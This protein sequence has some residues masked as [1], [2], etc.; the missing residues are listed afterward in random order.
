MIRGKHCCAT[1]G[2]LK[3][4]RGA[5]HHWW[6]MSRCQTWK[7]WWA[8][9]G[10]YYPIYWLLSWINRCIYQD[11]MIL[12]ADYHGLSCMNWAPLYI[13]IYSPGKIMDWQRVLNTAHLWKWF[14]EFSALSELTH[15]NAETK[16]SHFHS[17]KLHY[18]T[19][20]KQRL[21][22]LILTSDPKPLLTRRPKLC[23]SCSHAYFLRANRC[24][25]PGK[26]GFDVG[27]CAPFIAM[28][29]LIS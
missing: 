8:I 18:P 27:S 25:L 10:L 13:T 26:R 3:A 23:C 24:L 22:L 11:F 20:E 28:S 12:W 4:G 29:L 19:K 6:Q 21:A 7:G 2:S 15:G 16:K 1:S 17:V 5:E 14:L 9:G